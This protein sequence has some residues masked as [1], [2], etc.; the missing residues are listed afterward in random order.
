MGEALRIPVGFEIIFKT[1]ASLVSCF[2]ALSVK[3]KKLKHPWRNS[4]AA[5]LMYK[6]P[7][8][9][10][11]VT[12]ME[13]F[14]NSPFGQMLVHLFSGYF[15]VPSLQSFMLL[16]Q[17]WSLSSSHHT[18]TTYIRLSGGVQHKHF[19]RFY[20]FFGGAFYR[21]TDQL[22]VALIR[23]SASARRPL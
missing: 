6:Y 11:K 7:N 20:A 14:I 22:W 10:S 18:I 4:A 1:I 3:R 19:S 23:L 21:V 5:A 8:K 16:A 2:S 15:T 13:Y 12:T 9:S 17:G